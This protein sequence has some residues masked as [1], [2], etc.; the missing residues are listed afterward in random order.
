MKRTSATSLRVPSV[1]RRAVLAAMAGS[2][3]AALSACAGSGAQPSGTGTS[4]VA[5]GA[6]AG[7]TATASAPS[8]S[9]GPA[10]TAAPTASATTTGRP[11]PTQSKK[12]NDDSGELAAGFPSSVLVLMPGA[13]IETS[14]IEKSEPLSMASVT[15]SVTATPAAV[16]DFY[17][18]SLTG[19]GFAAQPGDSV[20]GVPTKTFL[21][22]GGQE[23]V[24]VSV[25]QSAAT[26][27]FTL[28][29]TLLAASFKQ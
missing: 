21:R 26:A 8:T 24:T 19:Q 4:T 16:L 11:A 20:D 13:T 15:A 10:A 28:G 1:S 7:T 27:T 23:S 25:A 22:A 3:A 2:A 12:A 29:A 9:A 6:S 14:S 5:G 18:Q 17:T